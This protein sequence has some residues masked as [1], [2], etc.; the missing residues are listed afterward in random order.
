MRRVVDYRK[1]AQDCRELARRMPAEQRGQLL[2]IAEEWDRLADERH[3][4]VS[5]ATPLSELPDEA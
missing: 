2:L 3:R 5:E 1:N 4:A